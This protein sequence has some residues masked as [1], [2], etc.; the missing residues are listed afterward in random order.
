MVN[1]ILKFVFFGNYFVGVLGIMLSLETDFQ[2][3]LPFNSIL[4]YVLLFSATVMYY[5]YAYTNPLQTY[6]LD[7]PRSAWYIQHRSF[8]KYSQMLFLALCVLTG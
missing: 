3:R 7:N 4:Y 1:K 6:S 8:V 5:T 2:L